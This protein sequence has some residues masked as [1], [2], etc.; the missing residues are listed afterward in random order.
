[1][2]RFLQKVGLCVVILG[3]VSDH[4]LLAHHVSGGSVRGFDPSL[5]QSRA[6]THSV[7][8][9]LQG[10]RLD[11]HLGYVLGY[12]FSGEYA[13]HRRLGVGL[14]L[15]VLSVREAFLPDTDRLGD[16]A[17]SLKGLILSGPFLLLAGSEF[18]FPTGSEARGTGAGHV[19][20]TP[21][22]TLVKGKWKR[23][24]LIGILGTTLGL[25]EVI[26]PSLD[27]GASV[28]FAA[29]RGALPVDFVLAWEGTTTLASDIF[30]GGATKAYLKP[31]LILH[32]TPKVLVN[33][34]VKL[35][36]LDTL[37]LKPGVALARQSTVPLGDAT[38]GFSLGVN[39]AF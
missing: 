35:S 21:T 18:S 20:W 26:R 11:G 13:L 30:V 14:T 2:R 7:D 19:Q 25:S 38:A 1:M 31:G 29:I 9:R 24:A 4:Q 36:V 22:L 8:F 16:V 10:D 5:S 6:P 17:L 37:K 27:Y 23:V 32:M 28:V 33:L 3:M 12:H 34:G 15:P 39:Y